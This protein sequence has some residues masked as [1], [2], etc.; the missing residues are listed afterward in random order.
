MLIRGRR[1]GI[2]K[3]QPARCADYA[4]VI[5]FELKCQTRPFIRVADADDLSNA[6]N[7]IAGADDCYA[8]YPYIKYKNKFT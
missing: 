6:L 8:N 4:K 2:I 1:E 7:V 3:T 5:T